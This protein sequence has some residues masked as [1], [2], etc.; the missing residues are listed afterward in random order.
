[1]TFQERLQRL[2]KKLCMRPGSKPLRLE[3]SGPGSLLAKR[4]FAEKE[5]WA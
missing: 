5:G 2:A 3:F 1:M 4:W